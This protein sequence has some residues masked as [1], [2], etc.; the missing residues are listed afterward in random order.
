MLLKKS[1]NII[2]IISIPTSIVFLIFSKEIIYLMAGTEFQA[3]IITMQLLSP[4]C[5]VVG[6]AYFLGY[7]VLYPQHKEKIYTKAV[8]ISAVFS[9]IINFF[10]IKYFNQNGAAMVAVLSEL[11]A[12]LIMMILAKEELKKIKLVDI[13][14]FKMIFAA[15]IFFS[16]CLL[17]KYKLDLS[18]LF[19]FSG[20]LLLVYGAFFLTLFFVK[21]E[22]LADVTQRIFLRYKI[23][24]NL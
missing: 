17:I 19:I 18:N 20:T 16:I 4:L 13:N 12:I 5:V 7:L 22:T 2:L 1:F 6:L 14:L 21:E 11:L 15:F 23:K 10:A 9:L 3:S 8:I 24:K